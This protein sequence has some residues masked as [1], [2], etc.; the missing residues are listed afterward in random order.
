MRASQDC[1][2]RWCNAMPAR[3]AETVRAFSLLSSLSACLRSLFVEEEIQL[4]SA[5]C[6]ESVCQS[7]ALSLSFVSAVVLHGSIV[8][9][10]LQFES[11][12]SRSR[13][14]L[15][16]SYPHAENKMFYFDLRQNARG[17][18]L[19]ISQV[20]RWFVVSV[21]GEV[22][23]KKEGRNSDY[24]RLA[25]LFFS[26]SLKQVMGQR[27]TIVVPARGIAQLR[28]AVEEVNEIRGWRFVCLQSSLGIVALV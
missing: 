20:D 14:S 11:S 15:I 12:H 22:G 19:K 9:S 23:R 28:D 7:L 24:R 5:V 6:S 13:I 25:H 18:F 4:F 10:L 17:R 8:Y 21:A 1:W 27:A 26:P 3:C 16:F 2:G